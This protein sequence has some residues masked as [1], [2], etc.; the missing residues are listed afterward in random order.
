MRTSGTSFRSRASS[1]RNVERRLCAEAGE[2][3]GVA[4][5]GGV[6][7]GAATGA[8]SSTTT[9]FATT[10]ST[11]TLTASTTVT[12][13]ATALAATERTTALA[14][15]TAATVT[16]ATAGT[17]LT[18]SGGE[19]ALAVEL[20]VDLLLALTLTLGLATRAGEEV[21]LLTLDLGALG[22][23]LS[24]ALVGLANVL[25]TKAQL[26]LSQLSEVGSVGLGVVLG[27]GL[28]GGS[29]GIL[30]DGILLLLL[31]DGLTGLLVSKLGL[32]SLGAPAVSGLLL[33]LAIKGQKCTC[34]V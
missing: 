25:L 23:V 19:H 15:A 10:T 20:N 11:T 18:G 12:T 32:A 27:L 22:E 1:R 17:T 2:R 34:L 13:A 28:S 33:V 8:S 3:A 31:G 24:A 21:L 7:T 4:D 16:T 9:A 14:T 26:L 30:L 29:L 6:A 5:V